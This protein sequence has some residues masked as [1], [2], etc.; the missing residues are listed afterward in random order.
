MAPQRRSSTASEQTPLLSKPVDTP[1][2]RPSFFSPYSRLLLTTLLLSTAFTL[3]AST[4]LYAFRTILEDVCNGECSEEELEARTAREIAFMVSLTTFSGILNLITTGWVSKRFGVRQALIWQTAWPVLRVLCQ[5]WAILNGGMPAIRVLQ[6]TQLITIG[7]GGAGYMLTA[8][9]YCAALV[10]PEELGGVLGT[11]RPV[12]PFLAAFTCLSLSTALSGC[13]LPYIPPASAAETA[14]SGGGGL[15]AP[16]K[17]FLPRKVFRED[18]S[19]NGRWYGLSFL[20]VGAFVSV[21]ATSFIPM[22]LQLVGT[23]RY[24]FKADTNGYLMSLA[25]LSRAGFLS[26]LFPRIIAAGRRW[27]STAPPSAIPPPPLETRIPTTAAEIEPL[28]PAFQSDPVVEPP[29]IPPPTSEATGSHFD[30]LFLRLSILLDG[31]LT[32]AVPLLATEGWHLFLAAGILP[33]ASGTAP[34]AKGVVLEMVPEGEQQDALQG[35]ALAETIAMMGTISASGEIFAYLS[36]IGRAL[37]TFYFNAGNA[38]L[39]FLI[40]VFVRFPPA[41]LAKTTPSA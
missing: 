8:N 39:A 29:P 22:L 17:V 21:F 28:E 6:W 32:A 20:G 12:Y 15:L 37:D 10:A 36:E 41:T 26:L 19:R 40:L 14:K 33:L 23:N 4:L 1:T 18:G 27:Y 9:T 31:F 7:G 25:A 13:F 30:L 11:L 35:I 3:T 2:S 34:A 24:A 5:T 16:I 38:L